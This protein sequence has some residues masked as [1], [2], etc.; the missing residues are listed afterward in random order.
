MLKTILIALVVIVV[1]FI[2]VVSMQPSEFRVTQT[3]TIS[4]PAPFVFAQVNDL[5]KWEE[6]SPWAKRDPAAKKTYEGPR[7]GQ[8]LST[9]GQATRRLAKEA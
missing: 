6:W 1:V 9:D 5:Y 2:V 4:A 3:A 8:A 7:R